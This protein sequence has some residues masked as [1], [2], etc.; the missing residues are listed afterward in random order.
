MMIEEIESI[1][2]QQLRNLPIND[3]ELERRLFN[4]KKILEVV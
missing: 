3:H 1:F 2:S 4:M